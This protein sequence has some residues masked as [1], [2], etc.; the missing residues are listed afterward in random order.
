MRH[1]REQ[2]ASAIDNSVFERSVLEER[3]CQAFSSERSVL[4]ARP[5]AD[6][7]ADISTLAPSSATDCLFASPSPA[8]SSFL[9]GGLSRYHS[10]AGA[11]SACEAKAPLSER[12]KADI[13]RRL[14]HSDLIA[15]AREV[16]RETVE[17]IERAKASIDRSRN[18]TVMYSQ[19]DF[20]QPSYEG[21]LFP[22]AL[23]GSESRSVLSSTLAVES[24]RAS[25]PSRIRMVQPS[26]DASLRSPRASA[27]R[28]PR[29]SL[30]HDEAPLFSPR[31][32]PGTA[33][34][35]TLSPRPSAR[36][37]ASSPGRAETHP[38]LQWGATSLSRPFYSR[39][40]PW[41]P[42]ASATGA[43]YPPS[44]EAASMLSM[45]DDSRTA[46]RNSA[47][48]APRSLAGNLA[49]SSLAWPAPRSASQCGSTAA[50]S[51]K[52]RGEAWSTRGD[53][54]APV[55]PSPERG[56]SPRCSPRPRSALAAGLDAAI[57]S[58]R[59]RPPASPLGVRFA[60]ATG[61]DAGEGAKMSRWG[62]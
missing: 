34:G 40:Q 45:Q 6:V 38:D 26:L 16:A 48:G 18:E 39:D 51:Q 25:E 42:H 59:P 56:F 28:T 58:P 10:T 36:R 29:E 31:T 57:C 47:F 46:L 1:D 15:R 22:P 53:F 24:L 9:A 8:S 14:G 30:G 17:A 13:S 12:T 33:A 2:R 37:P 5:Q 3:P 50:L 54:S 61:L 60:G 52:A 7:Y 49:R 32:F 55:P 20:V 41:S 11:A 21:C 27:C 23:S 35:A 4:D 44:P 43:A 62:L 19:P